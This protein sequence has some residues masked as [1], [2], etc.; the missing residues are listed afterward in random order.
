MSV[1]SDVLFHF[2]LWMLG[3]PLPA[4]D[5]VRRV[6]EEMP[7]AD[8]DVRFT[9]LYAVLDREEHHHQ[10]AKRLDAL[11]QVLHSDSTIPVDLDHPAIGGDGRRLQVLQWEV[12]RTCLMR[13]LLS[14]PVHRRAAWILVTR[15]G[16]DVDRAA[17][18]LRTTPGAIRVAL[19]RAEAHLARYLGPRCEHLERNSIC[20]CASRLGIALEAGLVRDAG[21]LLPDEPYN[22]ASPMSLR[23]LYGSLPS[24]DLELAAAEEEEP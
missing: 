12:K 11:E 13:V 3:E 15:L 8:P 17:E 14:L 4:R 6:L 18:L 1:A 24:I 9:H 16:A 23:T 2:A 21:L 22:A 5:F 7:D 20:R 19:T 10:G